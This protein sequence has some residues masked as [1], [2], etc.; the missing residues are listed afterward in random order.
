[1]FRLDGLPDVVPKVTAV[2]E[3]EGMTWGNILREDTA[4]VIS[5]TKI[6][7]TECVPLSGFR[8]S[9]RS[10]EAG[11]LTDLCRRTLVLVPSVAIKLRDGT[12]VAWAFLGR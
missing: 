10:G 3:E 9:E 1:M 6:P 11:G 12:P 7:R 4:L 5:R 2:M 8:P